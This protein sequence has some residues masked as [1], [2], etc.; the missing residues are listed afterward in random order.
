M[1]PP[2]PNSQ[3][4]EEDDIVDSDFSIDENDEPVS[5]HGD[6]EGGPGKRRRKVATK[7]YREPTAAKKPK[8]TPTKSAAAASTSAAAAASAPSKT[9]SPRKAKRAL[10]QRPTY[11]VMDSARI[12][13]RKST[14]AKTSATEQRIRVR[15]EALRKKP[16]VSK[17]EDYIPTQEEL[18]EEAMITEEENLASLGTNVLSKALIKKRCI[19]NSFLYKQK[20]SNKWKLKRRKHDRRSVCTPVPPFDIT[21]CRCH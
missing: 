20:N 11:T 5:D 19:Y 21:P 16:K 4:R 14:A 1:L 7:A 8:L 9:S 15:D 3:K 18:L 17:E 13:V 10:K 2:Q 12:S 6:E